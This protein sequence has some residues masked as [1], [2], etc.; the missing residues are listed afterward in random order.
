VPFYSN[1]TPKTVAH[2]MARRLLVD[3]H[4]HVYLPRYV[5]LLRARSEVPRIFTRQTPDGKDD[6]RLLILHDEPSHG[7]PVGPEYWNRQ[8]KLNFMDKHGIDISVLSSAN[9]WL[10]FLS[11]NDAFKAA[12]ELNE[13]LEDYCA[14]GPSVAEASNAKRFYGLGLLPLVS[15]ISISKVVEVVQ[16]IKKLPHLR[17]VILGTK[18]IGNG[19]DD[20]ALDEFWAAMEE[21]KLVAFIH[22]HYGLSKELWG[23]EKSHVLPLAIGFPVETTIVSLERGSRQ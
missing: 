9:P 20:P 4:T 23:N 13:D 1:Y 5:S 8:A 10:D 16:Q 22:P 7:R 17:G 12:T 14:S 18:G 11:S 6:D 21:S 15:G 2:Q 19:L 3:V